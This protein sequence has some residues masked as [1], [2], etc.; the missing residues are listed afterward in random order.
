MSKILLRCWDHGHE[1]LVD[2]PKKRVDKFV[3]QCRQLKKVCPDCKPENK[4]LTVIYNEADS[5]CDVKAY[6]C[7]HG[8]LTVVSAY[9]RATHKLSVKWGAD[10]EAEENVEGSIEELPEMIDQKAISC[11]HVVEG[12]RGHRRCG[13]KLKAVDDKSLSYPEFSNFKTKVR[14]EDVWKKYGVA[15]PVVGD[16]DPVKADPNNPFRPQYNATE[17]E[18]RNKERLKNMKRTRNIS[19]DR[20]PGKPI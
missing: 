2:I 10:H 16:Y 14:V 12:K 18:K 8:H 5:F 9:G 13:C 17:F 4:Q 7:R 11:N 3:E 1:V 15:D 6:Q 19:E 20:L